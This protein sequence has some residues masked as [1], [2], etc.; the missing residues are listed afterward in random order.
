MEE[1]LNNEEENATINYRGKYCL[2][3]YILHLLKDDTEKFIRQKNLK[4]DVNSSSYKSTIGNIN[5]NMTINSLQYN[6]KID[7]K[8]NLPKIQ[9]INSSNYLIRDEFNNNVN[10]NEISIKVNLIPN[11]DKKTIIDFNFFNF[12]FL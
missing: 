3:K 9:K 8:E 4:I 11:L 5:Y 12:F 2:I 7:I 1:Q 6:K 10:Y